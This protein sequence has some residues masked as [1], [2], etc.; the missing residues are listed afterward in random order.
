MT[1][2]DGGADEEGPQAVPSVRDRPRTAFVTA[3]HRIQLRGQHL[4]SELLAAHGVDDAIVDV[5]D[6][7]DLV[8]EAARASGPSSSRNSA[9]E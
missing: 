8:A 9:S 5:G 3:K 6:E 1:A 7:H 2:G 4:A